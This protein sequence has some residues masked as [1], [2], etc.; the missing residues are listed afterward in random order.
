MAAKMH[1]FS[2][3]LEGVFAL[4]CLADTLLVCLSFYLSFFL[5]RCFSNLFRSAINTKSTYSNRATPTFMPIYRHNA[6]V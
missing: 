6:S 3:P 1:T 5:A 2:V 4:L